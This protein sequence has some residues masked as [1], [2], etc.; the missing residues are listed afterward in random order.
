MKETQKYNQFILN[1]KNLKN[2]EKYLQELKDKLDLKWYKLAGV[3]GVDPSKTF[4]EN[5]NRIQIELNK[6]SQREEIDNLLKEIGILEYLIK[7]TRDVLEMMPD[8]IKKMFI[9][10]YVKNRSFYKVAT[11]NDMS[12]G[13]LQYLLKESFRKLDL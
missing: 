7:M 2:N 9:E 11:N 3:S 6:H 4:I 13:Q 5:P 1:L 12:I 10:V 8:N